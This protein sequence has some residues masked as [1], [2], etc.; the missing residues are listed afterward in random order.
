MHKRHGKIIKVPQG[1][2]KGD[3][4]A[5]KDDEEALKGD[6]KSLKS[7]EVVLKGGKEAVKDYE[8]ALKG[9]ETWSMTTGRSLMERQWKGVKGRLRGIKG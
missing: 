4:Q 9:T 7:A 1:A 8:D 5:L 6:G 3:V 2:L